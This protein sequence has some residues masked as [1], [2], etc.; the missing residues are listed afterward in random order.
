MEL[1]YSTQPSALSAAR[2][3]A[4][5]HGIRV[6]VIGFPSISWPGTYL[7]AITATGNRAAKRAAG[8]TNGR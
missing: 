3:Y 6:R 2:R 4:T 5:N 8:E 1:V 7:W